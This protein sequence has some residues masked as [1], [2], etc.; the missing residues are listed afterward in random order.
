MNRCL[1]K[2]GAYVDNYSCHKEGWA[3]GD[4]SLGEPVLIRHHFRITGPK[5]SSPAASD[6]QDAV[7]VGRLLRYLNAFVRVL[8]DL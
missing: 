6:W 7:E 8:Q 4:D 5:D 3:L 1:N 2:L